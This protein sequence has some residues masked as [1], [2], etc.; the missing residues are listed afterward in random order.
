MG[1]QESAGLSTFFNTIGD[2]MLKRNEE[3]RQREFEADQ[4]RQKDLDILRRQREMLIESGLKDGTY[5]LFQKP[6]QVIDLSSRSNPTMVAGRE[7]KQA[8]NPNPQIER[9][10][11]WNYSDLGALARE[12][13]TD[14]LLKYNENN[15]DVLK[16]RAANARS[17][18]ANV[19]QES[20]DNL[21]KMPSDAI[22]ADPTWAQKVNIYKELIKREQSLVGE[23]MLRHMKLI[24]EDDGS[25][26]NV[27]ELVNA[28]KEI[29]ARKQAE[30]EERQRK[31][32]EVKRAVAAKKTAVNYN[33]PAVGG[34]RTVITPNEDG[35]YNLER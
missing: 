28:L 6:K 15:P 18:R 14:L 17:A 33:S 31:L 7:V 16:I 32:A 2:D 21:L 27:N 22:L 30:E 5:Q 8:Y 1:Y 12:D 35:T 26:A 23:Q 25:D 11:N 34:S 9:K 3:K 20:L 13:D 4:Q 10:E 24:D 19:L 29:V